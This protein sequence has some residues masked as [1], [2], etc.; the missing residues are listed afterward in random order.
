MKR[1]MMIAAAL[2]IAAAADAFE[3]RE[4]RIKLV[5]NE[6]TARFSLYYLADITKN[7]YVPLLYDQEPRTS[8]PS[9][10]LDGKVF[11]LGDS[12]EYR[13]TIGKGEKEAYIEYR[14]SFCVV[15]QTFSFI[16]SEGSDMTDGIAIRFELENVSDRDITV[17]IRYLLDTYLG[18]K[19]GKHFSVGSRDKLASEY[20]L[21][22]AF[23]ERK[24]TTPSDTATSY[25]FMLAGEGVTKPDRVLFANWKR[26][27]DGGWAIDIVPTR[28][29]N[30]YPYS[31]NDSAVAVYYEPVKLRK[32]AIRTVSLL[33]GIDAPGGFTAK[34][35]D[36]PTDREP[37]L[38]SSVLTSPQ[39]GSV[40]RSVDVK[41]DLIA[42]RELLDRLQMKL[43]SGETLTPE[44][45]AEFLTILE[46]L[47]KRKESY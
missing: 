24:F 42:I 13:Y 23:E 14:S 2:A 44:E 45:T 27:Y 28:D 8:F 17:G 11:R 1:F 30:L 35:P 19:N 5:V 3:L 16:P 39:S 21:S 32:G 33:M 46:R 40:D 18:E 43:N 10:S 12:A 26:L 4:G 7:V 6:Q 38:P 29:F 41:T 31:V 15:R 37:E 22:G 47:K 36:S 25:A 34:L 9:L 20:S